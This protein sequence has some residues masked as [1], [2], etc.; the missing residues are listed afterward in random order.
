MATEKD[1]GLSKE[2]IKMYDFSMGEGADYWMDISAL[3]LA[4]IENTGD[5]RRPESTGSSPCRNRCEEIRCLRHG[6]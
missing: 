5:I 3:D 2:P 4:A 1:N 6:Q